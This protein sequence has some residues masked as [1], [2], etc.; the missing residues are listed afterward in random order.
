MGWITFLIGGGGAGA[1]LTAVGAAPLTVV[2]VLLAGIFL[3]EPIPL[4]QWI[5]ILMVVAG[6]G[7]LAYFG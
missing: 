7:V 4:S 2:T 3:R 5:G 6:G 1:P